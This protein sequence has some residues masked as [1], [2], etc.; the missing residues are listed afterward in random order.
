MDCYLTDDPKKVPLKNHNFFIYLWFPVYFG[1]TVLLYMQI[2]VFSFPCGLS[3]PEW[4]YV[5]LSPYKQITFKCK[6]EDV[7]DLPPTVFIF[8]DSR[9]FFRRA[10]LT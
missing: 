8:F 9:E 10:G 1:L 3:K 4:I 6:F 5:A 2:Q 7:F